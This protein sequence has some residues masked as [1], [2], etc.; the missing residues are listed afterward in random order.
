MMFLMLVAGL[1]VCTIILAI[2]L[3]HWR[4]HPC[5]KDVLNFK[6]PFWVAFFISLGIVALAFIGGYWIAPV[7]DRGDEWGLMALDLY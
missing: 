3:Y 1:P 7:L 4:K 6:R 2:A 5:F